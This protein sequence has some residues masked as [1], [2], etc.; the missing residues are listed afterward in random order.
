MKKLA[1]IS[2]KNRPFVALVC[3]AGI[4]LGMFS[5]SSMKQELIP[6]VDMPAVSVV[7]ISPGATSE[8]MSERIA[9]PIEQQVSSMTDVKKTSSNCASSYAMLTIELEY[10]TELSRATAKI[11]QA[12]SRIED[13]FP[14]NT[15]VQA[16]SG[17]SGDMPIAMV[18]VTT[19]KDASQT[20]Q[21]VRNVAMGHIEKID[22]VASAQ[23]IGA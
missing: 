13:S 3:I 10:G 1:D 21:I 6:Q 15:T 4:I 14:E 7:A 22:G 17:G 23:L 5:L 2:L 18:G 9:L 8:Q 20:A 12:I 16:T 19:G 11:E